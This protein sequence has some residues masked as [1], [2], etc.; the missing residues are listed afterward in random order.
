[1]LTDRRVARRQRVPQGILHRSFAMDR[2]RSRAGLHCRSWS[3]SGVRWPCRATGPW[4]SLSAHTSP[5]GPHLCR[6]RLCGTRSRPSS[7]GGPARGCPANQPTRRSDVARSAPGPTDAGAQRSDAATAHRPRAA[8][9]VPRAGHKVPQHHEPTS[10]SPSYAAR[11]HACGCGCTSATDASTISTERLPRSPSQSAHVGVVVRARSSTE[12]A[13]DAVRHR[14][15]QRHRQHVA[16]TEPGS[17]SR[18]YRGTNVA[19]STRQLPWSRTHSR[20]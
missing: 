20:V 8:R 16:A 19:A 9:A 1:M 18:T 15:R 17:W 10:S 14:Q 2:G 13:G 5:P 7:A 12:G 4:P 6:S 3:A 11:S